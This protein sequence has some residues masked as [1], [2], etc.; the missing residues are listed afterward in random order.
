MDTAEKTSQPANLTPI[1]IFLLIVAAF[2]VGS[3]WTKVQYLEGGKGAKTLGETTT[4]TTAP[5]TL[6]VGNIKAVSD[7]DHIRGNKNAQITLIEYSDL[8]CPYCKSFHPTMQKILQEYDGKVRWIYR[9]F[10]LSFHVN[11]QKEAEASEC[12]AELGGNDK[13]WEFI[14]KIFDRTTSNGTGF[15]IDK[16]GPLA[17]E[18]GVN[19]TKFQNC[20]DSGKY[21]QTVKDQMSDGSTGGITGTPGTIVIDGKGGKQLIPGALPYEQVKQIVEE[22]LKS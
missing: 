16:L 2:A 10:P 6:P 4:G 15:A 11:A 20:L 21:Q 12:V 8:E 9:H 7:S 5:T 22:A 13:F 18:I 19:Q 1:F 14:D 3:L 17:A